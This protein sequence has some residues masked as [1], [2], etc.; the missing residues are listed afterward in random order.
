MKV[1]N[2]SAH[3]YLNAL[4]Q[5]GGGFPVYRGR[6]VMMTGGSRFGFLLNAAKGILGPIGKKLLTNA[7]KE[8]VPIIVKRGSQVLSGNLSPQ[9]AMR[10]VMQD[11]VRAMVRTTRKS[12]E[13]ELARPRKK[14]KGRG[15]MQKKNPKVKK[16]Y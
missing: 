1:R 16:Y 7:K 15:L 10:A 4:N 9:K 8:I 11:S 13:D 3:V 6:R 2:V 5:R 14:Q 12:L